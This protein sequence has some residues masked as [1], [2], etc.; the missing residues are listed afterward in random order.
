[1]SGSYSRNFA[2]LSLFPLWILPA[3]SGKLEATADG[4][5]IQTPS[6]SS[7]YNPGRNEGLG[8]ELQKVVGFCNPFFSSFLV[9]LREFV[10]A[11][12]IWG[13]RGSSQAVWCMG[14]ER[15]HDVMAKGNRALLCRTSWGGSCYGAGRPLYQLGNVWGRLGGNCMTLSWAGPLMCYQTS[16]RDLAV[17]RLKLPQPIRRKRWGRGVSNNFPPKIPPGGICLWWTSIKIWG[18]HCS[19]RCAMEAMG[20]SVA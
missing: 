6:S 3:S 7:H 18:R 5:H 12:F 4:L 8:Q 16:A 10:S 2:L 19:V 11:V 20:W 13:G 1:M 17:S 14:S 9:L 15:Q